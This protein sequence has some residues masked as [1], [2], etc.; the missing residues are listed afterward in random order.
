MD[1]EH[2]GHKYYQWSLSIIM[3]MS[4]LTILI[5]QMLEFY[6]VVV[7]VV[8]SAVFSIVT[9]IAYL[10]AWKAAARHG[11]VLA[12]FYLAASALRMI[13]ALM[14]VI[15]GAF[16][17]KGDSLRVMTFALTFLAFYFLMLVFDSLYFAR[18]EKHNKTDK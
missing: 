10:E 1:I 7:P 12:K 17:Y 2:I 13:A 15:V 9:T 4:L 3:G 6:V 18:V 16:I 14:V 5:A 8:V 11:A